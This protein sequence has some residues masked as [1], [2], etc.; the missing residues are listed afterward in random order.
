MNAQ[1]FHTT[2]FKM[3][4]RVNAICRASKTQKDARERVLAELKF[5]WIKDALPEM[6][7]F[8]KLPKGD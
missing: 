4:Q 6:S 5:P 8:I 2:V 1:E 3:A 7:E